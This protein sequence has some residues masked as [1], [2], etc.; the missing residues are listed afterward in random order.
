MDRKL[1]EKLKADLK[2]ARV[3]RDG[4]SIQNNYEVTGVSREGYLHPLI[5]EVVLPRLHPHGLKVYYQKIV[6]ALTEALAYGTIEENTLPRGAPKYLE[7]L[8]E[9]A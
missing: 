8:L 2:Q 5:S 7:D 3:L 6:L 1:I 9:A 4:I